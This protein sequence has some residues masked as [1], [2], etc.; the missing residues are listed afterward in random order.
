MHK[1]GRRK[2]EIKPFLLGFR[3][4]LWWLQP[5]ILSILIG[6]PSGPNSMFTTTGSPLTHSFSSSSTRIFS[7]SSQPLPLAP[8]TTKTDYC[9]GRSNSFPPEEEEA[10]SMETITHSLR[11]WAS[12]CLYFLNPSYLCKMTETN[13]HQSPAGR[14]SR[15]R[16]QIKS[17]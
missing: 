2:E 6:K 9:T 7:D 5:Q 12:M 17:V 14:C 16:K 13:I 4:D 15:F 8:C 3:L 11:L 1:P 10:P